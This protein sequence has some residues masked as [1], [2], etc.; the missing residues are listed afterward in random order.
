MPSILFCD[1]DLINATGVH[2]PHA[3]VG[4]R[5]GMIDYVG[6]ADPTK[7]PSQSSQGAAL[8]DGAA[9]GKG[10]AV[11][12]GTA[13]VQYDRRYDGRGK[14]LMPGL[15]N[16]HSHVPMTL[17]R[18]MG[19]NM[20]LD[21][22]LNDAIF[23]FEA[24]ITDDDAYFAT[25][26]GIAEMLRFGVVS[27][28]DMY[29]YSE[30][31]AK[32]LIESGFKCNLGHSVLDFDPDISYDAIPES[33]KNQELVAAYHG[34][35]HG[36]LLVDFNLHAEYTSTQN[37]VEGLAQAAKEAG[38]R[39]QVH[40]A[41]T[42]SVVEGCKQRHS[43]MTP[44]EYLA[45]CGLFDVPTTAAHCVWLTDHDREILAGKGVFVATCPA[46]NAKLG[47]GIADVLAMRQAGITVALGTDGV[48]SNNAH[49]MFRDM[50]L[51]A[52]LQ[53]AQKC[54]PLGLGAGE[55][56]EIATRNGALSQ[57]RNDCGDIKRGFKADLVVLDANTPWM[58]PAEDKTAAV[59]YSAQG[60]DMVL[61]MVDGAVLY[62]NGEFSTID[63]E[64]ALAQV[65]AS[66]ARIMGELSR[67]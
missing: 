7:G 11:E 54:S 38:V 52:L 41:E 42:A 27:C 18:G 14:I 28:T 58:V 64:R 24:L 10:M 62:E 56:I 12:K 36:R 9:L 33:K 30:A 46:S 23:P 15:Y 31:R 61:T 67:K 5:D 21:S 4:V 26:A 44:V 66:R 60:S 51:L 1:I 39:M 8:D 55:V 35:A 20:S 16:A 25:L 37:V 6:T 50:Y 59:V 49:N 53:R 22:W 19:D 3:F 13:P 34:T 47:S 29:Y 63:V 48:A 17:L 57:G 32:A 43:G 45:K 65:A 40:V 2:T